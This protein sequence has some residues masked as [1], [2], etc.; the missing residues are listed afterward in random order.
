VTT[1]GDAGAPLVLHLTAPGDFGG[2][3]TAVAALA[4]SLRALRQPVE[5]LAI[6]DAG[7]VVTEHP[8]VVRLQAAGVP[9]RA[10]T[11]RPRAYADE[12]RA[13]RAVVRETGAAIVHSH[14]Y[15]TDVVAALALRNAD[16]ALISTAHGFTGG[17]WKNRL[18]EF[19]QSVAWRR[20]ATVIAVSEP[21]S[22]ILVARGLAEERVR[23]IRNAWRPP[24]GSIPAAEARRQ[25][26]IEDA[27]V[28]L[29]WVGRL[30]PEKG[31]DVALAALAELRD[32]RVRL[33]MIG[34]GRLQ[35]ELER[36]ER[37]LDLTDRIRW[38]GAIQNAGALIAAFELF[39]LSSR[40]EG[41]PMV[42]FEAMAAG[43]PIVATSVGG[44]PDVL[45]AREAWLVPKED[46]DALARMIREALT[47]R[48]E[49]G[50]RAKCAGER[51]FREFAV[52]PWAR[53]HLAL[54]REVLSGG[55][56]S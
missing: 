11:F 19:L 53:A 4:E 49:R 24:R 10:L 56:R 20:F 5:V 37:R 13:L 2:R 6:L 25:L 38:H 23:T 1:V 31:P 40:S 30:S 18:Y 45:S 3:E 8:F 14:G 52:E 21:L 42:L 41:T 28:A 9:V 32:P 46:P 36:L 44:V 51:L 35:V 48:E 26:G 39:L 12:V 55:C 7:S 50:L 34:A 27:E 22:R 47:N 16:V 15:R 29:G 43:T 33:H 17:G 54:Y